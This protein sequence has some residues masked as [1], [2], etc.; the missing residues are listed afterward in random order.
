MLGGLVSNH[1]ELSRDYTTTPALIALDQQRGWERTWNR[2]YRLGTPLADLSMSA[3][4]VHLKDLAR[5][6][7][8]E[9]EDEARLPEVIAN[10]IIRV[11]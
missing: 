2:W 11:R 5:P 1:P 4:V 7:F 8:R 6:G 3:P 9:M 10:Y